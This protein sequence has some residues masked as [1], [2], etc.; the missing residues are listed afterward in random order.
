M[1]RDDCGF[2]DSEVASQLPTLE[3]I[4][5][6]EAVLIVGPPWSG[7]TH[8][9]RNLAQLVKEG[10]SPFGKYFTATFF[11]RQ[12]TVVDLTP[13]WWADWQSVAG[14]R[15]CWLVDALDEDHCR[16]RQMHNILNLVEA[17]TD[18]V[19]KRLL[20]V[21]SVRDSERPHEVMTRLEEI[22]GAVGQA[23]R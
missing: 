8:E 11:E 12:G 5:N 6:A 2:L 20:L 23:G 13:T 14:Q 4:F 10:D 1:P 15:A 16:G 22:Y 7:K 19:R 3:S 21:M 9:A 17:L 18:D